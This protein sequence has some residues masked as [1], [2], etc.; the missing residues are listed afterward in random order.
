MEGSKKYNSFLKGT[1][2]LISPV[3][4][5]K[6]FV[7]D[8]GSSYIKLGRSGENLPFFNIPFIIGKSK[9]K[10]S[11]DLTQTKLPDTFGE[12]VVK[13]LNEKPS[14]Y[15]LIYPFV[16]HEGMKPK[17]EDL[18][19]FLR[20]VFE[21]KLKIETNI[22]DLLIVDSLSMGE[23]Y[24]LKLIEMLFESLGVLSVN[25]IN[26]A[27]ASLFLS[28]RTTGISIEFG[29]MSSN[30][31]PI[32]EG[33]ILKHAIH[34]S[35]FGG[36]NATLLINN[37]LKE[38]NIDLYSKNMDSFEIIEKIKE[39]LSYVSFNYEN[40][41]NEEKEYDIEEI[42][43]ELPDGEII[44]LSNE[45]KFKTGEILLR[46]TLIKKNEKNTKDIIFEKI[47]KFETNLQR[48][49]SKNIVLS[50]GASLTNNLI[51]RLLRDIKNN[52]PKDLNN[53][54]FEIFGESHRPF[55]AWIGGSLVGSISTFQGLK[56]KKSEFE[57]TT[58]DKNN[59]LFKKLI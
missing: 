44:K 46:P 14:E 17:I 25:F 11:K 10:N 13:F 20:Y 40:D 30:I 23:E 56:I 26:S 12:N 48:T 9:N 54:N 50:G 6:I 35:S 41:I 53:L 19:L 55:S 38:K 37:Y 49:L 2:D 7:L 28:G 47:R 33:L 34:V 31:V 16:H 57:E 3:D 58:E 45:I 29:N 27:I 4:V 21:E 52:K 24:R 39:K 8:I 36:K 15:D 5:K 42:C 59:F 1:D 43:F 51:P 22:L 18:E 32:Y